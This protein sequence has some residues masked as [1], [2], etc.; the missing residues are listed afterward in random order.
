VLNENLNKY[1]TI[2]VS[3]ATERVAKYCKVSQCTI[4]KIRKGGKALP[5]EVLRTP[6]RKRKGQK[7]ATL[8]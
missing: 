2:P 4:K 6:G 3:K 5:N 8:L 1:L 7:I